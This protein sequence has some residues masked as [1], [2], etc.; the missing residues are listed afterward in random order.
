MQVTNLADRI[1]AQQESGQPNAKSAKVTQRSQGRH[2]QDG[3]PFCVLR[4]SFAPFAFGCPPL[5]GRQTRS[6][7]AAMPWPPPMHIVTSA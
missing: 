4:V 6:N 7:S 1:G 5:E 3:C 2:L